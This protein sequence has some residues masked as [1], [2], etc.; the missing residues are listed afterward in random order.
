MKLFALIFDLSINFPK[1]GIATIDLNS[2]VKTT[3]FDSKTDPSFSVNITLPDAI[4][5]SRFWS[6]FT[7]SAFIF[8][9]S[10]KILTLPSAVTILFFSST[11]IV[12][13]EN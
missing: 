10:L 12:S 8:L 3:L 2:L 11:F 7:L 13:L 5:L 9:L 1:S 4:A 6:Y